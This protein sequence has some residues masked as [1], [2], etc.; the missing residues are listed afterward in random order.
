MHNRRTTLRLSYSGIA[1]RFPL[2]ASLAAA[3]IFFLV[4]SLTLGL[5]ILPL[6]LPNIP[7]DDEEVDAADVKAERKRRNS[8]ASL[9]RAEEKEER[10][11]RRSMSSRSEGR[12][13]V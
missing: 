7:E 1:I 10:R 2:A 13:P 3:G 8:S 6:V 12:R 4:L 11:R 9:R 5:C